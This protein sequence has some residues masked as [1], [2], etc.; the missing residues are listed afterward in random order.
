MKPKLWRDMNRAWERFYLGIMV[1]VGLPVLALAGIVG[2]IYL[3]TR[4]IPFLA[5]IEEQDGER[6]LILTLMEPA[7]VQAAYRQ[8]QAELRALRERIVARAQAAV[9]EVEAEHLIALVQED[10]D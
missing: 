4:K 2:G 7:Q 6:R 1:G 5:D 10:A 9:D 8:R 3:W